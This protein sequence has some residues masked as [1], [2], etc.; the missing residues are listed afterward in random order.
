MNSVTVE[1]VVPCIRTKILVT[2][3]VPHIICDNKNEKLLKASRTILEEK[4]IK[5]KIVVNMRL[6]T[7][8]DKGPKCLKER[9]NL[10][11]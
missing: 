5:V 8:S 6:V 9:E 10:I 3:Q 7:L 1:C 4:Q 2:S 11:V